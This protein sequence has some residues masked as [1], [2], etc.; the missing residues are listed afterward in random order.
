[1]NTGG[2]PRDWEARARARLAGPQ[3]ATWERTDREE[4]KSKR[5]A[6]VGGLSLSDRASQGSRSKGILRAEKLI[7]R[8]RERWRE[9]DRDFY[10][11]G[12][13][14]KNKPDERGMGARSF[15]C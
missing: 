9:R 6:A 5:E 15:I 11:K 13:K 4:E 7:M 2:Q 14:I 1:M 3:R 8:E 12:F 10:F